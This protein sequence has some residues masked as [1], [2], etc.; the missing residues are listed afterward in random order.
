MDKHVPGTGET[1]FGQGGTPRAE[2]DGNLRPRCVDDSTG[3][4]GGPDDYVDHHDLRFTRNHVV[5]VCHTHRDELV[6]DCNGA[7][8]LFSFFGKLSEGIH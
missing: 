1:G 7:W 4:I 2:D 8:M 5:A 6:W 3:G